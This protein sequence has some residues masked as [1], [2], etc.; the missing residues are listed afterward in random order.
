MSKDRS[1]DKPRPIDFEGWSCL[2]RGKRKW[3]SFHVRNH[4]E[5]H[6]GSLREKWHNILKHKMLN[7]TDAKSDLRLTVWSVGFLLDDARLQE[8]IDRFLESGPVII[9]VV[10][11]PGQ[12]NERRAKILLP[13]AHADF[14]F[15]IP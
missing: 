6:F 5:I 10:D 9:L 2:F 1:R 13:L 4:D 14:V 7:R 12:R 15:D 8:L 3:I 11:R